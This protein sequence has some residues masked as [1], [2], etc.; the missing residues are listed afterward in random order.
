ME[1]IKPVEKTYT[2]RTVDNKNKKSPYLREDNQNK[3]SDL[4]REEDKT[5]DRKE[6]D[7]GDFVDIKA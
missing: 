4:K 1:G 3:N 6:S 7:K 5:K 2:D